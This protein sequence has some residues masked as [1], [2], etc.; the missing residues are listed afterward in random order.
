MEGTRLTIV[1]FPKQPNA[2]EFSIRTPVTPSRWA[3]FDQVDC[4]I[5][6]RMLPQGCIGKQVVCCADAVCGQYSC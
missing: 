2:Y 1:R 6:W 3:E 4:F 5:S